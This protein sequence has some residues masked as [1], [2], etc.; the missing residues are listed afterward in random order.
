[1]LTIIQSKFYFIFYNLFIF[2]FFRTTTWQR[3]TLEHVRNFQHWQSQQ[4]SVMQQCDQRFLYDNASSSGLN[5][6][7]GD[8]SGSSGSV[9][10]GNG[11][12]PELNP[13]PEGWEKRT[14]LSGRT[15]YVNH[16]NK[17]TQWEDP[18]TLGKEQPN[19]GEMPPGWEIKTMPDGKV[20]FIDHN[21]KTTTFQDPRKANGQYGVPAAYERSFR[22]KLTQFRYLCLYNGLPSHIKIQVSRSNVFEDSFHAIMRVPPHELRRRLFIT[23]RGEEGLDYGGI[24]REWFFLLSHEVNISRVIKISCFI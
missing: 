3:P 15:Y 18:R 19:L 21:T 23:F 14:D 7:N 20:Y 13:L 9:S 1:M 10:N 11:F 8:T 12:E 16:K 22:W 2:Y 5:A 6:V 17:T 4:G 24:A